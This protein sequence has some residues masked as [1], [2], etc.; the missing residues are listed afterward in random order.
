VIK[1][2]FDFAKEHGKME[3]TIDIALGY[4]DRTNAV[5]HPETSAMLIDLARDMLRKT[6]KE[7]AKG[8]SDEKKSL[9]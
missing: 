1:C 7:I 6:Q 2:T 4:L 8:R 3:A 9:G 5:K